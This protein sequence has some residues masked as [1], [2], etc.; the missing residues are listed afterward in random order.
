MLNEALRHSNSLHSHLP[1]TMSVVLILPRLRAASFEKNTSCFCSL[2]T[3]LQAHKQGG[4]ED[5]GKHA[6]CLIFTLFQ[7]LSGAS[8]RLVNALLHSCTCNLSYVLGL[9]RSTFFCDHCMCQ[10]GCVM[11]PVAQS[12]QCG[13]F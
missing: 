2:H 3:G 1:G 6:F 10:V 8:A 12:H 7:K 5:I 13:S 11:V 9:H 4:R